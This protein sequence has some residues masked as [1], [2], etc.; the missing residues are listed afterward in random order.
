MG[1]GQ[2]SDFGATG[3][4]VRGTAPDTGPAPAASVETAAA[5]GGYGYGSDFLEQHSAEARAREVALAAA[6]P[7]P[8]RIVRNVGQYTS[9]GL[10][11]VD[12][13]SVP[14]RHSSSHWASYDEEGVLVAQGTD[15]FCIPTDDELH[16]W[17]AQIDELVERWRDR[18]PE[19]QALVQSPFYIRFGELPASGRS[20][21]HATGERESGLSCYTARYDPVS[22]RMGF[23]DEGTLPDSLFAALITGQRVL[24]VTGTPN[25]RGSDGEPCLEPGSVRVLS[26]LTPG[27][28]GYEIQDMPHVLASL[29]VE[30]PQAPADA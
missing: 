28:G 21:N 9:S 1:R 4:A 19:L 25:G 30:Q 6:P 11:R 27:P 22:E 20:L 5:D 23:E 17:Q 18:R 12:T 29:G 10:W 13:G 14:G 24:L 8:P 3:L 2:G 26:D 15:P 16:E 7:P